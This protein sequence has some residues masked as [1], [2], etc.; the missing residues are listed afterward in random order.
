MA[1]PLSH[2]KTFL[3]CFKGKEEKTEAEVLEL[4][5]FKRLLV[6]AGFLIVC[7]KERN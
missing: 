3:F 1:V 5:V 7:D 4:L 6:I 2:L